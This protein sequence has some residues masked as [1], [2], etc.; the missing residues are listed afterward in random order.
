MACQLLG[1]KTPWRVGAELSRFGNANSTRSLAA[2]RVKTNAK[3]KIEDN[4]NAAAMRRVNLKVLRFILGL[5][6]NYLKEIPERIGYWY[7]ILPS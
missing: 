6:K 1:R 3:V 5:L 4:D 2:E 7:F